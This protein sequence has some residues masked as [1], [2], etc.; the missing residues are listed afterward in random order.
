[1][2][3]IASLDTGE[4]DTSVAFSIEVIAITPPAMNDYT[5]NL[6][7]PPKQMNIGEY[8]ATPAEGSSSWTYAITLQSGDSLPSFLTYTVNLTPP[9]IVLEAETSNPADV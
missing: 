8:I 9:V 7:D 2:K 4:T 6:Y 5:V 1:M 3:V